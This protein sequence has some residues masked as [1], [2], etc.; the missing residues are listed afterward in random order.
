MTGD[1]E[2]ELGVPFP[3]RVLTRDRWT[4]TEYPDDGSPFDWDRVFGRNARRV[5]DLGCG[6]GRYL[7]GSAIARPDHDHLGIEVVERLVREASRSADRRGLANVRLATGDAATWISERL[8]EDSVD[9]THIY[10]PQPYFNPAEKGRRIL[11][12]DFLERL[13]RILRRDGLLVLQSDHPSYWRYLVEAASKYF[14][15]S[16]VDGPWPDA[17]EGRT[18]REIVSRKKGMTVRRLISRRRE[19]P[20]ELEIP[21]VEFNTRR[22]KR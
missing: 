19:K 4:S 11:T 3:G 1:R 17:P 2:E 18:R 6:T 14:D 8:A 5:V 20:L 21:R 12:P 10:H 13:W 7:I 16:P 9:E 15:P 22:P